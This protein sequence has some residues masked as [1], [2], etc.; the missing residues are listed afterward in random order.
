MTTPRLHGSEPE[1]E[2]GG[3][4]KGMLKGCSGVSRGGQLGR[5]QGS[6]G[7]FSSVQT[8]L[9]SVFIEQTSDVFMNI[10]PEDCWFYT[11]GTCLHCLPSCEADGGSL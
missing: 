9:I 10:V 5:H 2:M 7:T 6:S 4:P 8:F 11:V 3:G 1:G